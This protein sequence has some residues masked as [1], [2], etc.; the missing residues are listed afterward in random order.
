MHHS[1]S[2]ECGNAI[3][4]AQFFA[5]KSTH[6]SMILSQKWEVVY[7]LYQVDRF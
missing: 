2:Q 4:I 3:E 1:Y 7:G 5:T 6:K